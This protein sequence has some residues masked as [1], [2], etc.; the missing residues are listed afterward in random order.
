MSD[1]SAIAKSLLEIK[2]VEFNI[3]HPFVYASGIKSPIYC[4]NRRIISFP[5]VR[6]QVVEGFLAIIKRNHIRCDVIAGT[7][8]AGIPHAAWLAD[9]LQLPML[10]VRSSAKGHGKQNQIEGVPTLHGNVVVIEDLIST[11]ASALTAVTALRDAGMK[12]HDVLAVF[13]YQFKNAAENFAMQHVQAHYLLTLDQLLHVALSEGLL[14][15]DE[16]ATVLSWR[17]NPEAWHGK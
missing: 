11:G 8:T 1:F 4:D 5:D 14:T 3:K 9:R 17:D 12:V 6:Q 2:V 16:V 7:A 10:Y 13:S 15:A